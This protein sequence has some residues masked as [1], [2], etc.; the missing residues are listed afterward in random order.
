MRLTEN[1]RRQHRELAET[2]RE[3]LRLLQPARIA[4]EPA[5]VRQLLSRLAGT[6]RV[7]VAMEDESLYPRL[8]A[9]ADPRVRRKAREFLDE[10]GCIREVFVGYLRQWPSE[11]PIAARPDEFVADTRRVVGLLYER[12]QRENTELH[13]LADE[14]IGEPA[15]T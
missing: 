11:G 8:L 9:H 1:L 12:M 10:M 14:A 3:I 4:V 2:G 15:L 13:R 6:L 7:H 5:P